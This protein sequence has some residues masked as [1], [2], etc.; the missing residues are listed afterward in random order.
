LKQILEIHH[1]YDLTRRF[2]VQQRRNGWKAKR[3][4]GKY[5]DAKVVRVVKEIASVVTLAD[6]NEIQKQANAR[7]IKACEDIYRIS[8]LKRKLKE[9]CYD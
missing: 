7:M 6:L 3:H 4:P 9:R 1:R 8:Q 5:R 2:S